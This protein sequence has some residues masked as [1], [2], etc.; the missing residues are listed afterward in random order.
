MRPR[1]SQQPISPMNIC[2]VCN[3]GCLK[4]RR[5]DGS[6]SSQLRTHWL[7]FFS[8]QGQYF[9][10]SERICLYCYGHSQCAYL[11]L[12]QQGVAD[13]SQQHHGHQER[14]G[15]FGCHDCGSCQCCCR[16]GLLGW[17]ECVVLLES[18]LLVAVDCQRFL[19]VGKQSEVET[20]FWSC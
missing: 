3:T 2:A 8:E 6:A 1:T 12:C 10:F 18:Q 17:I 19:T 5:L 7:S 16:G 20:R 13:T 14:N 15:G 11:V 9:Q 4:S